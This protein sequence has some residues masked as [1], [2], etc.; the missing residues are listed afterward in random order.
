MRHHGVYEQQIHYT[1]H[2]R[3]QRLH[4]GNS[5]VI[6]HSR[7]GHKL[8]SLAAAFRATNWLRPDIQRAEIIRCNDLKAPH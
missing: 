6:H 3:N 5:G 7:I 8:S 2:R 4:S 1:N